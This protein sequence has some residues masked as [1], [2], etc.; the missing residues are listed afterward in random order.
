MVLQQ[1]PPPAEGAEGPDTEEQNDDHRLGVYGWRKRCLYL[2][3]LLLLSTLLV[4][5]ALTIWILRVTCLNTVSAFQQYF[6]SRLLWGS[7][8]QFWVG[9]QEKDAW[10]QM[11]YFWDSQGVHAQSSL[12]SSVFISDS[13]LLLDI[14]DERAYLEMGFIY[15]KTGKSFVHLCLVKD[16]QGM[17]A[18][19]QNTSEVR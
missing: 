16:H 5:I 7:L 19:S 6:S 17:S 14:L 18:V 2:L 8:W 3:V 10:N 11:K 9:G 4:N 12:L 15:N 1:Y 13:C